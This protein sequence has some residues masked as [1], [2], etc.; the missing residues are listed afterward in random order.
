M[1]IFKDEVF[2]AD[3]NELT[4]KVNG[5]TL[6]EQF[7][8]LIPEAMKLVHHDN[9]KRMILAI[10]ALMKYYGTESEIGRNI[11]EE[12]NISIN[13]IED[14]NGTVDLRELAIFLYYNCTNPHF[15]IPYWFV[16]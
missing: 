16:N 7:L 9:E 8:N 11:E 4:T 5:D 2:K 12:L 13:Y 3:I 1:K 6:T 15:F 14:H 10:A